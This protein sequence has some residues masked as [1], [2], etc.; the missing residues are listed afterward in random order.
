MTVK[1]VG[2]SAALYSLY[3]Q[4]YFR[5]INEL[6]AINMVLSERS[7]VCRSHN[8]SFESK[9]AT[10]AQKMNIYIGSRQT[11]VLAEETTAQNLNDM[12][13]FHCTAVQYL[14]VNC[15]RLSILFDR[16]GQ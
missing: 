16:S 10:S 5:A 15:G 6:M 13:L 2:V 11:A 3:L 12:L 4:T 8:R 14:R 7:T 1:G 9:K